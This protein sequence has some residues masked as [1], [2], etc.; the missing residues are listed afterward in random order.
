MTTATLERPGIL[1]QAKTISTG[2]EEIDKKLGG[3]IPVGSL[4]LIEGESDSGKSVLTQQMMWGS[5]RDGHRVSLLTTENTF[6]SLIRQM[7]SLN[8]DIID[9]CLL[10]WFKVYPVKAM[11]AKEGTDHALQELL[12]AVGL[13]HTRDVVIIDSLTSFIAHSPVENVMGFFEECKSLCDQGLTVILVAHSYAFSD[14]TLV[15][16]SSLCDAHLRLHLDNLGDRLMKIL[17][18]AKVRGAQRHTGNIVSFDVEP[19]WGMRI[20]PFS[21][22]KA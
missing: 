2:N 10:G 15:R 19:G 14:S 5:L 11:R 1:D 17:E 3:G 4:V 6:K 21:K 20:I 22:A 8:L 12:R 16:I 7:Q 9:Q 13:Q 18:V